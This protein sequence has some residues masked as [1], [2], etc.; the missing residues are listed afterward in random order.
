MAAQTFFKKTSYELP[1]ALWGKVNWRVKKDQSVS[2]DEIIAKIDE[3]A[4]EKVDL[5]RV[6]GIKGKKC[7]NLLVKKLGEDVNKGELIAQKKSIFGSK[8]VYSPIKGKLESLSEDGQLQIVF[9]SGKE[10]TT[11]FAGKINKSTDKEIIISFEALEAIG[12]WGIGNRISGQLKLIEADL[13]K[14][15]VFS[16]KTDALERILLIKGKISR[17]FWFKALSLGASGVVCGNLSKGGFRKLLLQQQ[18]IIEKSRK[19]TVFPSLIVMSNQEIEDA[20]WQE[21]KKLAGKKVLVEG[22]KSRLVIPI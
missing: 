4:K 18:S 17:A 1:V 7:L 20:I 21:F 15:D 5:A 11:D 14:E 22:E 13:G 12:I 3:V 6:F 19:P 10:I 8:K 9:S 2:E 16:I